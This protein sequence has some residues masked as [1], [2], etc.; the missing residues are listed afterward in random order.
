MVHLRR[1]AAPLGDVSN[2]S[3]FTTEI[4]PG[5]VFRFINFLG[6]R[7]SD[8]KM[9]SITKLFWRQV[10]WMQPESYLGDGQECLVFA[11]RNQRLFDSIRDTLGAHPVT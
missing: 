5:A 11:S 6:F 10:E 7:P 2:E 4:A 8:P 3:V 1:A 9:E